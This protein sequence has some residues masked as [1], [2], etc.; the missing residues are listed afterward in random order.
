LNYIIIL[1]TRENCIFAVEVT[2]AAATWCQPCLN[3][4]CMLRKKQFSMI[5]MILI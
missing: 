5:V 3:T 1:P 2:Y 4:C